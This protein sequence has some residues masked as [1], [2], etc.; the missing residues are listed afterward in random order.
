[1]SPFSDV[2]SP[3]Q[4]YQDTSSFHSV[5]FSPALYSLATRLQSGGSGQR[6]T[7]EGLDRNAPHF[8][9]SV[10]LENQPSGDAL[11]AVHMELKVLSY[12]ILALLHTN[13]GSFLSTVHLRKLSHSH[14]EGFLHSWQQ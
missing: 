2:L 8:E 10:H 4:A 14:L 3:V 5:G 6:R 12:V 7:L 9:R 13:T 11:A 1:M